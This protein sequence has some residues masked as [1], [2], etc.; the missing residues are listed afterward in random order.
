MKK[1][2]NSLNL[3]KS[4]SEKEQKTRW[5][6]NCNLL[7]VWVE[8]WRDVTG[9]RSLIFI[10][11]CSKSTVHRRMRQKPKVQDVVV[12][13]WVFVIL[14]LHLRV[15]VREQEKAPGKSYLRS[16][17]IFFWTHFGL[18]LWS[19]FI[20]TKLRMRVMIK[21][22][23]NNVSGFPV[24]CTWFDRFTFSPLDISSMRYSRIA[25]FPYSARIL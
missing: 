24:I 13:F 19:D 20:F 3:W 23:H 21:F 16:G 22:L 7:P 10:V 1:F 8:R 4:W 17:W 11:L 25:F 12:A 18:R 14:H 2:Q 9:K 6:W 5:D 15:T